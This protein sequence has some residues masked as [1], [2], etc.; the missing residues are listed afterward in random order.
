VIGWIGVVLGIFVA[1]LQL[2]KILKTK[3][4]DGISIPTYIALCGALI[5]YWYHAAEI[6]DPVFITAQ[7]VN[8]IANAIILILLLRARWGTK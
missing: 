5:C 1:P 7:S 4:V 8:L 2:Y 3:C 6:R